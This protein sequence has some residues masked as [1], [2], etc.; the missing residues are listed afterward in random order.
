MLILKMHKFNFG[1]VKHPPM[2]QASILTMSFHLISLHV[3]L[4]KDSNLESNQLLLLNKLK[5][6]LLSKERLHNL[7]LMRIQ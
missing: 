1:V 2:N 6:L 3:K 5:S 7:V 4:I